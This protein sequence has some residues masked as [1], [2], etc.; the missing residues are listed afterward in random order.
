MERNF[1]ISLSN[2]RHPFSKGRYQAKIIAG[3]S[4]FHAPAIGIGFVPPLFDRQLVDEVI[5]V[6]ND[7][8]FVAARHLAK[9]EGICAGVSAGAAVHT[10]LALMQR[11]EMEGKL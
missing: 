1:A 11:P 2:R 10:S 5:A 3:N 9:R 6:S 4:S 7:D 8:A